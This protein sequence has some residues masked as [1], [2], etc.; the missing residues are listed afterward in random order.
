MT[1]NLT[2]KVI[3]LRQR[4]KLIELM[5]TGWS[6]IGDG[7]FEKNDDRVRINK[8]DEVETIQ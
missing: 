7:V 6:H 1:E 4:E 5:A 8:Y 2:R 3:A